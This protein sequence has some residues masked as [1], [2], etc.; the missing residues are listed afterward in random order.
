[1]HLPKIQALLLS[2]TFKRMFAM[3]L[4]TFKASAKAWQ[5]RQPLKGH[6]PGSTIFEEAEDVI[7]EINFMKYGVQLS[8]AAFSQKIEKAAGNLASRVRFIVILSLTY[9]T[10][11]FRQT[12]DCN[13]ETTAPM[14]SS[15]LDR[16]MA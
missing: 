3:E 14:D 5:K 15:G 11:P 13:E 8:Q 1:M 2:C 16:S 7:V 9:L 6:R 10:I 12:Y 4:L